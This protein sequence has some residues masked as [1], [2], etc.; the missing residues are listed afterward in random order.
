MN[1]QIKLTFEPKL[2]LKVFQICDVISTYVRIYRIF[3]PFSILHARFAVGFPLCYALKALCST[4]L[5]LA[6]TSLA[7]LH[8]VELQPKKEDAKYQIYNQSKLAFAKKGSRYLN[9]FSW[10]SAVTC[11]DSDIV[12][13]VSTKPGFN[14]KVHLQCQLPLNSTLTEKFTWTQ[15]IVP[16]TQ[17]KAAK[18]LFC[19]LFNDYSL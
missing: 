19:L 7:N 12:P 14:L 17:S 6:E 16:T 10:K 4:E 18:H 3:L 15:A 9:H 13:W 2:N 5:V 8:Q 11:K 1:W